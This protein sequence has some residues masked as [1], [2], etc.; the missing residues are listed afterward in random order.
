MKTKRPRIR[1]RRRSLRTRAVMWYAAAFVALA[2]LFWAY[3]PAM[4]TAFLFD[5]SKQQFAIS[6]ASDPLSSWIGPVRPLLMFSY[7]VNTRIS[8]QDTWSYHS[9]TSSSTR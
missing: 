7:L 6:S 5:D 9:S 2:A 8:L 1:E 4:H 3:G